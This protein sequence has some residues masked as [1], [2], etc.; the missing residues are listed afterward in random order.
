VTEPIAAFFE[1]HGTPCMAKPIDLND[2]AAAVEQRGMSAG[3]V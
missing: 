1:A 3:E 2:L